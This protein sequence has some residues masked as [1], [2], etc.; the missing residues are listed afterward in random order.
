MGRAWGEGL[1]VWSTFSVHINKTV[2][3]FKHL[4][5][6]IFFPGKLKCAYAE[7]RAEDVNPFVVFYLFNFIRYSL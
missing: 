5:S 3:G 7:G 4:L 6:C 1:E 2:K